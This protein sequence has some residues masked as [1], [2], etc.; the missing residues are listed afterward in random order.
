MKSFVNF[1][2]LPLHPRLCS[3]GS[4]LVLWAPA[5]TLSFSLFSSEQNMAPH[6]RIQAQRGCPKLDPHFTYP[7]TIVVI[8]VFFL[9]SI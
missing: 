8:K 7:V 9:L 1:L 4:E 5:T 6:L 3:F 2:L